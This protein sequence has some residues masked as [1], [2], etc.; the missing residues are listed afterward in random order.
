MALALTGT[1]GTGKSSVA[2]HLPTAFRPAEVSEL[3]RAARAARNLA[4]GAVEV[5]LGR[6]RAALAGRSSR[7]PESVWV[8][9]LAHLLPVR[10]CV[11]LRCHPL[12]L[13]RR[14]ERGGRGQRSER[15]ENALCEATDVVLSEAVRLHRRIWEVD[16]TGRS[17]A[18]VARTVA[19]IVRDR[20][21]PGH[22]SIRWLEDPQV[23]EW[24]L[25][26]SR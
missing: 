23:T 22:G 8:G 21:G 24:L 14:L 17:P 9:H 3:A 12:E 7:E 15:R 18:Q 5:D 13:Y 25:A 16:T 26:V 10:D 19:R 1:P 20:T 6:L 4:D 11:V 2:R